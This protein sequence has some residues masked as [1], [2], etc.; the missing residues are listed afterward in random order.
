VV[1]SFFLIDPSLRV[2]QQDASV[3]VLSLMRAQ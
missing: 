2:A 3:Q 1:N